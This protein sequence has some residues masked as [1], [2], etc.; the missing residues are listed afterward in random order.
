MKTCLLLSSILLAA[1]KS[2]AFDLGDVQF[3]ARWVDLN[4]NQFHQGPF[5]ITYNVHQNVQDTNNAFPGLVEEAANEW[6][7]VTGTFYQPLVAKSGSNILLL[8][9]PH[10]R[11]DGVSAIGFDTGF[12]IF[13]SDP[14]QI[15]RNELAITSVWFLGEQCNDW[16]APAILEADIYYNPHGKKFEQY[17]GSDFELPYYDFKSVTIHELGHTGGLRHHQTASNSDVMFPTINKGEVDVTLSALDEWAIRKLYEP[18]TSLQ[19]GVIPCDSF[20]PQIQWLEGTVN[21]GSCQCNLGINCRC[22]EEERRLLSHEAERGLV[23]FV[24]GGDDYQWQPY[25][26]LYRLQYQTIKNQQELEDIATSTDT[27]LQPLLLAY[28]NFFREVQPLVE[29]TFRC[30]KCPPNIDL[31][32]HQRH[33]NVTKDLINTLLPS[34]KDPNLRTELKLLRDNISIAKGKR[35]QDATIAYDQLDLGI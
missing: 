28:S 31:T 33:I 35:L 5:N 17:S 24:T 21:D 3:M 11:L 13:P 32:V 26:N 19:A 18:G 27:K 14:G 9:A 12:E 2:L 20:V 1:F 25:G 15:Q 22:N 16:F 4:A 30:K 10:Q 7:N 6:A 34:I 29:A 8:A 23:F